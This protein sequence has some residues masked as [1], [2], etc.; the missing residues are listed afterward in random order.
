MKDIPVNTEFP[1]SGLLP[2]KETDVTSFLNKYPNYDGRDTVIA[3]LDSGIDPGAPG[4][5]QT[6]DGKIKIIERFD[7]SGCGDV[8]TVSITPKEGY[9][10]TLTGKKLK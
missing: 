5:Q 7:C 9:I 8:N 1:I 4:L 6:I 3:I 2:K 10:E